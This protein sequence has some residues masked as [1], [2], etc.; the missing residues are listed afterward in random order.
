V[1][2][3]AGASDDHFDTTFF[4]SAGEFRH[5]YRC[6]VG[7]DDVLLVRHSEALR[8][9]TACCIVS[10]SDDEPITTG[11]QRFGSFGHPGNW[12]CYQREATEKTEVAVSQEERS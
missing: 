12:R 10:Q 11:D 8:I 4:R 2:G 6:P 5:P 9:A 7:R 1:R 3:A